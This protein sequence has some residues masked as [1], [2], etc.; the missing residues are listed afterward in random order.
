[1]PGRLHAPRQHPQDPDQ[2]VRALAHRL[3]RRELPVLHRAPR[4]R[5]VVLPPPAPQGEGARGA[6]EPPVHR[7]RDV[8]PERQERHPPAGDTH[9]G[10]A[11]VRS[12][13]GLIVIF[14]FFSFHVRIACVG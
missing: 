14:L 1:M 5:R 6:L 12:G 7:T 4:R 9:R 10:G 8:P 3:L 13:E 11:A 2:A